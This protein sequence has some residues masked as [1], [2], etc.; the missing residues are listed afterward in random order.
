M[1]EISYKKTNI[2]IYIIHLFK[3]YSIHIVCYEFQEETL[4]LHTKLEHNCFD[5][6][7]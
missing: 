3:S 2:F 4:A 7:R 5:Q 1:K 6:T